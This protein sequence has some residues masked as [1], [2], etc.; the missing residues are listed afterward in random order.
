MGWRDVVLGCSLLHPIAIEGG[1]L[2]IG[3]YLGTSTV[4]SSDGAAGALADVVP[5]VY[6]SSP[7]FSL[8]ASFTKACAASET[9]A[10]AHRPKARAKRTGEGQT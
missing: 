8:G 1:S 10:V 2:L 3:L 7:T 5:W 4:I 6:P 9:T